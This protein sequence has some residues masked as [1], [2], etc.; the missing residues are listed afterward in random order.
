[1]DCG[2]SGIEARDK[3]VRRLFFSFVFRL[4]SR[5]KSCTDSSLATKIETTKIKR[6]VKK[7][8]NVRRF[9]FRALINRMAPRNA[10]EWNKRQKNVTK[11]ECYSFFFSFCIGALWK[12]QEK[13]QT[14]KKNHLRQ[15]FYHCR[16]LN[17][18][19]VNI[20]LKLPNLVSPKFR[21]NKFQYSLFKLQ[22][23][24]RNEI[25]FRVSGMN[26]SVTE[27]GYLQAQCEA[28]GSCALERR[29]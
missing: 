26:G 16:C 11:G 10:N 27:Q 8:A 7:K 29:C 3:S 5:S 25:D 2:W 28:R 6:R 4:V 12:T 9:L 22:F 17:N 19:V 18:K 23:E 21:S 13:R 24:N 15:P 14:Y 20:T 1:M